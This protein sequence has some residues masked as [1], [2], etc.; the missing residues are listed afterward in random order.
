MFSQE[1]EESF[2]SPFD[3]SVKFFP[4]AQSHNLIPISEDKCVFLAL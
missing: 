2:Q 4:G 3:G 1:S